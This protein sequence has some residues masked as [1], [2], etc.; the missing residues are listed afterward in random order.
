MVVDVYHQLQLTADWLQSKR[1]G[2]VDRLLHVDE[3]A[4]LAVGGWVDVV[5]TPVHVVRRGLLQW[6][7]PS[8][9]SA[10]VLCYVTMSQPTVWSD[11]GHSILGCVCACVAEA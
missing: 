7:R 1:V 5:D 2:G 8:S 6:H 10:A 11:T 9:V 3:W 4:V